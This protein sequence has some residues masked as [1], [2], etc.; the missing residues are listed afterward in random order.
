MSNF[1]NKL[2]IAIECGNL[3]E[4]QRIFSKLKKSDEL[5]IDFPML[6][7][8]VEYG[9]IDILKCCFETYGA[10]IIDNSE[11]LFKKLLESLKEVLK[12]DISEIVGLVYNFDRVVL[13]LE[14]LS[15]AFNTSELSEAVLKYSTDEELIR[16]SKTA[17]Q[18]SAADTAA[19]IVGESETSFDFFEIDKS[20]QEKTASRKKLS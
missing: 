16:R 2:N 13:Y 12:K 5:S 1:Q 14:K 11:E 18:S 3:S 19:E 6:Q 15:S 4:V 8:V 10:Y 20:Q 7:K 9:Q 17:L